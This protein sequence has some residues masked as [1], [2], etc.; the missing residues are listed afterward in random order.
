MG[1]FIQTQSKIVTFNNEIFVIPLVFS[2]EGSI[3]LLLKCN[4][5]SLLSG[6]IVLTKISFDRLEMTVEINEKKANRSRSIENC[7][8]NVTSCNFKN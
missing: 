3:T 8:S 6:L 2:L 1:T 4:G 5:I 7:G